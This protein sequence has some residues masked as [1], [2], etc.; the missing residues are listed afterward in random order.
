[1]PFFV[2]DLGYVFSFV[3]QGTS[4]DDYSTSLS[5]FCHTDLPCVNIS[6]HDAS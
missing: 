1:M 6:G 2:P 5:Y 3:V 4:N